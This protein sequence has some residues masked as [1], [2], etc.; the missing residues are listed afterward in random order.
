MAEKSVALERVQP[1]ES[2]YCKDCNKSFKNQ[3][4]LTVHLRRSK[5]HG[6]G[7]STNSKPNKHNKKKQGRPLKKKFHCELHKKSFKSER[8]LNHHLTRMHKGEE[9]AIIQSESSSIER[10]NEAIHISFLTG[11]VY[12]SIRIYCERNEL[13]F[14][15]IASRVAAQLAGTTR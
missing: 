2:F 9:D 3:F 12:E 7:W 10:V 14:R 5:Q 11:S 8:G 1:D 15:V 4:A 13:H 6:G